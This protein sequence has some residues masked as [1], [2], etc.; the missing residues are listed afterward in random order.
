MN[1]ITAKAGFWHYIK[2]FCAFFSLIATFSAVMVL[3]EYRTSYDGFLVLFWLLGVISAVIV[4]PGNFFK[5]GLSIMGGC[6]A[7]GWFLLPFPFDLVTVVM[8]VAV[9]LVAILVAMFVIPAIFTIYTYITDIRFECV[10]WKKDLLAALAGIGAV[11][12]AIG[13]FFAMHTVTKAIDAKQMDK[14][15][16]AVDCYHQYME[17]HTDAEACPDEALLNPVSSEEQEDGYIRLYNCEYETWE[18]GLYFANAMEVTYEYEDGRW[19]VSETDHSREL[20]GFDPISGS[21]EGTGEFWG[22]FCPDNQYTFTLESL[23]EDGGTGTMCIY[24]EDVINENS[25]A[26]IEVT[27]LRLY[28]D[29]TTGQE[30]AVADLILNLETPVVYGDFGMSDTI[31]QVDCT[32]SLTD[33]MITTTAFDFGEMVLVAA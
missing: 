5:F 16:D 4:A 2:V 1:N 30:K 17:D 28:K 22:N 9:G 21:W 33:G 20:S 31:T 3:T 11:L 13:L 10:D 6:A 27:G 8:S 32:L 15:F 18:D 12:V 29:I 7:F 23:T 26:T 24:L 19:H 25:N 14:R